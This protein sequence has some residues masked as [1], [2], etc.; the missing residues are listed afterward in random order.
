MRIFVKAFAL[1]GL[2]SVVALVSS[3][4]AGAVSATASYSLAGAATMTPGTGTCLDCL[5][6]SAA[7]TGT[8]TCSV[9]LA[10]K[11]DSGSF[12]LDLRTIVVFPPSPCRIKRISG[13]LTVSWG[14]GQTSTVNVSGHLIDGK[15]ILTLAGAFPASDTTFASDSLEFVLN[16]FPPS[17]CT[18]AT[19][20]VSG[21][22][23]IST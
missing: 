14:T 13:T 11:P 19:N 6:P 2:V 15:P 23:T 4:G 17:P 1:V 22:L 8:A 16:N 20:T 7:A 12:S 9:C 21:A 5:P 3:G 10:G 18:A